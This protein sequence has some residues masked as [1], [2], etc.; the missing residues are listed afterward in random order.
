MSTTMTET[1]TG[2]AA[3][4]EKKKHIRH[5][6]K[7]KVGLSDRFLVLR[8]PKAKDT[9]AK[10]FEVGKYAGK[11]I[12]RKR[13][14]LAKSDR[15][16]ARK[17]APG[18]T[19]REPRIKRGLK[20]TIASELFQQ[21]FKDAFGFADFQLQ[22]EAVQTA[23]C[24]MDRVSQDARN[25]MAEG[26]THPKTGHVRRLCTEDVKRAFRKYNV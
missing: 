7:T 25:E 4:E 22:K 12:H 16:R 23:S 9:F 18:L 3:G 15:K 6:G 24:F 13:A 8:L 19:V 14:T 2:G 11:D 5:H 1:V 26:A 10:T 21:T 20:D 17:S